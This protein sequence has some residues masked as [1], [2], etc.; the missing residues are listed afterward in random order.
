MIN[1]KILGII[2]LGLGLILQT[3]D[4]R[5]FL[6]QLLVAVLPDGLCSVHGQI[7]ED[8]V[9]DLMGCAHLRGH[10]DNLVILI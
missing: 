1:L 4:L 8:A 9:F 5:C 6:I 7:Y 2:Q 10:A 3:N